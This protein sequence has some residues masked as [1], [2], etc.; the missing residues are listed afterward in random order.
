MKA[1]YSFIVMGLVSLL[2]AGCAP[3]LARTNYGPEEQQWKNYIQKSYNGW[4]APPT[5]APYS[6]NNVSQSA[7][8]TIEGVPEASL[9]D[10][11]AATAINST[12]TSAVTAQ[13]TAIPTETS[14]TVQKGDTLWSIA[15]KIYGDGNQWKRI[16]EANKAVLGGS[17]SLKA[18]MV[19][20]IPIK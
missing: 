2:F 6:E 9:S 18:G 8:S 3:E 15:N 16:Q 11:P 19:L 20:E 10:I 5:P 7:A 13:K 17:N 4:E 14:Y 1:N 12:E